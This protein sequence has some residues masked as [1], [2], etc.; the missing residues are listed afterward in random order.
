M[1]H[2]GFV[3]LGSLAL[4]LALAL[5]CKD[6][7]PDRFLATQDAGVDAGS[8]DAEV[9]ATPAVDPTLG[10][11]CTDDAQCDDRIDCTFDACDKGL[12]RCRN[13]PDDT[14]CGDGVY[15][16][17]GERCLLRQGCV[18]GAVVTCQDDSACTID[19]CIEATRSCE[20]APR[21]ADGD[22]DPDDHCSP[23]HDCD[24]TDPTV[25]S[26]KQEVCG[27]FRDDNC[28]GVIDEKPCTVPANDRC[29]TAASVTA[30]SALQLTTVATKLDYPTTCASSITG[31][32][33]VVVAITVPP[34]GGAKDV[35]VQ[36]TVAA[37]G[38]TVALALETT[39]G[40]AA[41]EIQCAKY[42]ARRARAI[43]RSRPA[44]STVY[45]VV[46]TQRE[47]KV[48][49]GVDFA[50]PTAHPANET[51]DAPQAIPL[52]TAVPFSLIDAERDLANAC[53]GPT[54]ELTYAFTLPEPRDVR[55][56]SS[57]TLGDTAPIVGFRPAVCTD[58]TDR[59]GSSGA[60]LFLRALAKGTYVLDVS[61]YSQIDGNLVVVTSPATVPAADES[62]ATAPELPPNV[63]Q[64]VDL[65]NHEHRIDDNCPPGGGGMIA[66]AARKLVITEP[67]DVLLLAR[68]ALNETGTVALMASDCPKDTNL[69]CD[70]GQ[71]PAK[72]SRRGVLPGEYRVVVGD[73]FGQSS[74]VT[75]LVRPTASPTTVDSNTCADAVTIPET[76]GFFTG[77]T[78]TKTAE[79][80]TS[81]DAANQPTGTAKD[82]VL[83]LTL[84]T[85]RRVV[86][87]MSGSE[88]SSLIDVRLGEPCPGIA[89]QNACNPSYSAGE[90][91][92]DVNLDPGTYFVVIDGYAGAAGKWN[93]DVRVLDPASAQPQP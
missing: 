64:L 5:G 59:C 26:Q 34:G 62:C 71:S 33:D 10:G 20:H 52:D 28:N 69:V 76:G 32:Q 90:A 30:P 74:K 29:E 47:G 36:A 25:N 48:D 82:Q 78:S 75:A 77:D 39:C 2:A 58:E 37:S 40:S 83:K 21:D 8:G 1:K 81:C 27:N 42:D 73:Q 61:S 65:S 89:V 91:F 72:A 63:T 35:V 85:R 24:D 87:D 13:T 50:A 88:Y 7:A 51:C 16:N 60:P 15:C 55:I 41:S 84:S 68:V 4:P 46:T 9:D 17:G 54:G 22:G 57:T 45:A 80:N 92:L 66:N 6:D 12:S 56:Y 49:L 93:L 70:T 67:S 53:S 31:A 3:L 14:R 43:A 86:F 79:Y 18:A 44:G 23:N 38:N 19:R 11:P